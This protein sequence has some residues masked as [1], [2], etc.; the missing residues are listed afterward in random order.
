MFSL[1]AQ[2]ITIPVK[3]HIEGGKGRGRNPKTNQQKKG[4]KDC[5]KELKCLNKA[6]WLC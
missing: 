2:T 4:A 1:V 6:C 3:T 5:G